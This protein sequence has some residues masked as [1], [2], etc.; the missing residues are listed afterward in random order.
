MK[1]S[2]II[3]AYNVDKFIEKCILSCLDQ[4]LDNSLY[5]IIII[6]DGSK[7]LTLSVL[8]QLNTIYKNLVIITQ[9]NSGLGA[10]RNRGIEQARGELLWFI[11][12]DDYIESNILNTILLL[13]QSSKLD[14]L[15]LNYNTVN[16]K[17]NTITSLANNIVLENA[18]VTGSNFYKD[19]YEKSYSCFF[20]FKKSLFKDSNVRFKERINMQ[21]S[22]ILPKIL[23]KVERLSFINETCYYYVQHPDSFT[24]ST[25][26]QKR[27]K[28]FESIIEVKKSLTLFSNEL[29]ENDPEMQIGLQYKIEGLKKIIFIHLVYFNYNKEWLIKI[30]T[31]L[32]ENELYPVNAKVYGKLKFIK[33]CINNYPITTK[34]FFDKIQFIR[35]N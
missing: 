6:D 32:K 21:D 33:M 19:N 29:K 27:F 12:G 25:N 13:F 28:Y 11:D 8:Q 2:L 10:V 14:A 22:E 17:Y 30:I 24:N 31:L 23:I 15:A 5:E 7:D 20:V 3:A 4:N 35:K 34:W 18:V 26:G 16:A 1:I 9:E